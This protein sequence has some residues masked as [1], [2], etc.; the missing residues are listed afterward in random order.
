IIGGQL[1]VLVVVRWPQ[2]H[3]HV[4]MSTPPPGNPQPKSESI[5]RSILTVN[6]SP[7]LVCSDQQPLP[8]HFRCHCDGFV[9]DSH[10]DRSCSS[11]ISSH[12]H[13]TKPRKSNYK[14]FCPEVGHRNLNTA[15][16][17]PASRYTGGIF[18]SSCQSN[19]CQ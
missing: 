16:K 1:I 6:L 8:R 10:S 2:H 4:P 5:D 3:C 19:N 13:T 14:S 12:H 7:R 17:C 15:L 9:E 18:C 11:C